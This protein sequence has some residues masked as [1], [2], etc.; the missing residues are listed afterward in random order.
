M[1]TMEKG[2]WNPYLAGALAGLVSIFS[3][4]AAGKYLGASTSFVKSAAMVENLF[5]P[6]HVAGLDYFVKNGPK[7][8]WQ[9]MFVVGILAGALVASLSSGT[10]RFQAVPDMWKSRFG[11]AIGTRAAIAFIGGAVAMFGARLADG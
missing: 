6:E 7:I 5:W 1:K 3:V 9:W 10:F 11:S 2:Q 4:W 8:D